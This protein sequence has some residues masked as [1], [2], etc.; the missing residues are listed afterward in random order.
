MT[1]QYDG[2]GN[3]NKAIN[4][5]QTTTYTYNAADQL[6]N[7]VLP[8][9]TNI[10]YGYDADGRRVKQTAGSTVTNYQWDEASPYGD[11]VLE[12]NGS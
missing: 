3:L 2:R 5:T 12:Y 9:N 4:G 6:S 8:N 10:A 11:V 7:V 1:Y